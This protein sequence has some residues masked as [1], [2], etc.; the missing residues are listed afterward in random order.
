MVQA[1]EKKVQRG[2]IE[3]YPEKIVLAIGWCYII[4]TIYF[5]FTLATQK[6]WYYGFEG[7]STKPIREV[8]ILPNIKQNNLNTIKI[9]EIDAMLQ[10]QRK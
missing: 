1:K 7:M 10:L 6:D 9:K 2:F 3:K 5:S 4:T 8:G